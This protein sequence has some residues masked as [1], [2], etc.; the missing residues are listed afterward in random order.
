[1]PE[2]NERMARRRLNLL[3]SH[4]EEFHD[5]HDNPSDGCCGGAHAAAEELVPV[6]SHGDSF[7]G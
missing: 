6:H 3:N 7:S 4:S 2:N 5:T 1:M